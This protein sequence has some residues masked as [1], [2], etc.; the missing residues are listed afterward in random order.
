MRFRFCFLLLCMVLISCN[1]HQEKNTTAEDA[2]GKTESLQKKTNSASSTS[3]EDYS[4]N[5]FSFSLKFPASM[6]ILESKLAGEMPVIN[7]YNP[8]SGKNPP[9]AIHEQPSLGYIAFLP[10]GYGVD[11]PSGDEISL[12]EWKGFLSSEEKF[13]PE[14]SKVY[15]LKNGTAW[16]MYLQLKEQPKSWSRS[17]MI[18]IHFKLKDFQAECLDG[19]TGKTKPLNECEEMGGNDH[20][21]YSGEVDATSKAELLKA[22]QTLKTGGDFSEKKTASDFL[23]VKKPLPNIEVASPLEIKGKAK[24]TWFFEAQVPVKLV[25]KD[26]K[27]L[28]ESV[29]KTEGNWMTEDF[30]PFSGK[31]EFKAPDDERGYLIFSRANASG[32]PANEMHYRL[33]VLF[34]PK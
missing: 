13:D 22:L 34:P 16:A 18:Y 33:P 25:D 9:F 29:I 2:T 7:L 6:A 27:V 23:G 1:Q 8:A 12:K 4:N 11:G 14:E 21:I 19:R 3:L 30:V 26:G 17:G 20:L 10:K 5:R 28:S 31:L 32:K 24:G 15:L